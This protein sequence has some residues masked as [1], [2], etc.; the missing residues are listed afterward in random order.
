MMQSYPVLTVKQSLVNY[1]YQRMVYNLVLIS[2][3]N[4]HNIALQASYNFCG[5]VEKSCSD[6]RSIINSEG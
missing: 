1:R 2:H 3:C 5:R 6:C 4:S